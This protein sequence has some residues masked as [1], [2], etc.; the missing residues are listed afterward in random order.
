M[1]AASN[2]KFNQYPRVGADP[3]AVRGRAIRHAFQ[4]KADEP[5]LLF[6]GDRIAAKA[7]GVAVAVPGQ[8]GKLYCAQKSG[9]KIAD[10]SEQSPVH[11]AGLTTGSQTLLG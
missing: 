7:L 2:L 5:L 8:D 6:P 10:F 4:I 9:H 3:P 1:A 11:L